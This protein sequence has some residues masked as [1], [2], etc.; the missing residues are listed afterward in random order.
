MKLSL[1]YYFKI[2][3]YGNKVDTLTDLTQEMY[4]NMKC[5]NAQNVYK[6]LASNA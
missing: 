2:T 5:L 3:A 6:H 4:T 1:S